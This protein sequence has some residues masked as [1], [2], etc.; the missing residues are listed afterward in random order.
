MNYKS[1]ENHTTATANEQF[2]GLIRLKAVCI[3]VLSKCVQ[4]IR[5]NSLVQFGFIVTLRH[6]H[7]AININTGNR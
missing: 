5:L 3:R 2:A 4:D 1:R 6:R 7:L